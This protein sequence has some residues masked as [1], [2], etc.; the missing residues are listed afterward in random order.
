MSTEP[1]QPNVSQLHGKSIVIPHHKKVRRSKEIIKQQFTFKVIVQ[2]GLTK[3]K[4]QKDGQ[5]SKFM[6]TQAQVE[7]IT[8]EILKRLFIWMGFVEPII[9]NKSKKQL[10]ED[11]C[12]IFL[13]PT[14]DAMIILPKDTQNIIENQ[15]SMIEYESIIDLIIEYTYENCSNVQI[16]AE[17]IEMIEEEEIDLFPYIQCL[18]VLLIDIFEINKDN[19]LNYKIA[20]KQILKTDKDII[21]IRNELKNNI[22]IVLEQYNDENNKRV[23]NH[24]FW[25]GMNL[26]IL[27]F[28]NYSMKNYVLS[29]NKIEIRNSPMN[30]QRK[31]S[32]YK[33]FGSGMLSVQR[34]YKAS[35][36]GIEKRKDLLLISNK[37]LLNYD[38]EDLENENKNDEYFKTPI[39]L[40]LQNRGNLCIITHGFFSNVAIPIYDIIVGDVRRIFVCYDPKE[41]K[42]IENKIVADEKIYKA[43][44][45]YIGPINVADPMNY[46]KKVLKE[47]CHAVTSRV[48]RSMVKRNRIKDLHV[49]QFRTAIKAVQKK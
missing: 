30:E 31:C 25:Y 28:F 6:T 47:L 34:T 40:R 29:L 8:A 46:K 10:V 35:N 7:A 2:E 14:K 37:I 43:F 22:D 21:T 3:L 39:K 19:D 33:Y 12:H 45:D 48:V 1:N 17:I 4:M 41:I 18:W 16:V 44:D 32:I 9:K 5:R 15:I 42:A 36:Y 49:G 13:I 11:L 26:Q 24:A 23:T 38:V 27:R 20:F